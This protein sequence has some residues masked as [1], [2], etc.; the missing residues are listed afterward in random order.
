MDKDKRGADSR[1]SED[2]ET[3]N[4]FTGKIDD[5]TRCAHTMQTTENTSESDMQSTTERA[6]KTEVHKD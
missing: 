3:M 2:M 6:G 1:N 5:S 4:L